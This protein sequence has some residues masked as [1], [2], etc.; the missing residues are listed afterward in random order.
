MRSASMYAEVH[1][2]S[3]LWSTLVHKKVRK[4]NKNSPD[5][6]NYAARLTL[7]CGAVFHLKQCDFMLDEAHSSI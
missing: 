7:V 4:N 3:S 2:H 1:L 6:R 5:K